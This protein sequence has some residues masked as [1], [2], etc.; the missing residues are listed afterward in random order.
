MVIFNV[1]S[2]KQETDAQTGQSDPQYSNVFNFVVV[3][4]DPDAMDIHCDV[5][6]GSNSFGRVCVSLR[7]V[8]ESHAA[9][10]KEFSL[11]GD[12]ADECFVA[13]RISWFTGFLH[14]VHVATE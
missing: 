4:P 3:D 10:E 14:D 12:C 9:Y 13:F 8:V 2:D 11:E 5:I 6:S 7:K 1:N